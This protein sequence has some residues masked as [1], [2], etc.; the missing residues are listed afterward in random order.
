MELTQEGV[1]LEG[2]PEVVTSLKVHSSP[3][4]AAGTSSGVGTQ[5]P[6]GTQGFSSNKSSG[7]GSVGSQGLTVQL[8]AAEVGIH[9]WPLFLSSS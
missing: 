3:V 8:C 1:A 9:L 2:M 5:V 4:R 7:A 6:F